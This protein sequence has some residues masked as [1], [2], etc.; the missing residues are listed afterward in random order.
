MERTPDEGAG[1]MTEDADAS[2][3][4]LLSPAQLSYFQTTFGSSPLTDDT[5]MNLPEV[6]NSPTMRTGD[7]QLKPG[8]SNPNTPLN[9]EPNTTCPKRRRRKQERLTDNNGEE[10][11]AKTP[12]IKRPLNSFMLYRRM[13]Q[14]EIPF[15]NHQRVSRVIGALWRNE[16]AETKAHFAALADIERATHL[17]DY[18]NYKFSPKKRKTDTDSSRVAPNKAKKKP[19]ANENAEEIEVLRALS[20]SAAGKSRGNAS[21][22]AIA[23]LA[24][25]DPVSSGNSARHSQCFE[26]LFNI[27]DAVPTKANRG[28]LY[29]DIFLRSPSA[30]AHIE[31]GRPNSSQQ[32][33][34]PVG[35]GLAGLG[36]ITEPSSSLTAVGES[37][38]DTYFA[39]LHNF[40]GSLTALTPFADDLAHAS[41]SDRPYHSHDRN[42]LSLGF[43]PIED[44]ATFQKI[45]PPDLCDP[46]TWALASTSRQKQ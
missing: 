24:L 42:P 29:E 35:L 41:N 19:A 34:N 13:K 44:E 15:Q 2:H 10:E 33:S 22:I 30:E 26:Q 27:K 8:A 7:Q 20:A 9:E 31:M 18:P 23:Q 17:R 28:A 40:S 21:D 3:L 4:S 11:A 32:P 37:D 36:P 45:S 1:G 43:W 39:A 46:E 12:Q 25:G 5:P 14:R 16:T 6:R 38:V